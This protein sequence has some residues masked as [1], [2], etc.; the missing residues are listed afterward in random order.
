MENVQKCLTHTSVSN[1]WIPPKKESIN[2]PQPFFVVFNN[3]YLKSQ[4]DL[5][6]DAFQFCYSVSVP[7]SVHI[8][9]TFFL[10]ITFPLSV[11]LA[12]TAR[13]CI[14]SIVVLYIQPAAKKLLE[15]ERWKCCTGRHLKTCF[16]WLCI[17]HTYFRATSSNATNTANKQDT[18]IV[19]FTYIGQF[20]V[21]LS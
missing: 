15:T 8:P 10:S 9:N 21:S 3:N 13:H 12:D 11:L 6:G 20:P 4:R 2:A 16:P 17:C 14:N 1:S 19:M 18:F 7:V 5:F